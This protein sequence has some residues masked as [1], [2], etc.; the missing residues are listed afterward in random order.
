QDSLGLQGELAQEIA[1]ALRVKLTPEESARV[2]QKPTTNAQAYE[3]YL[4]ARQYEFKPDTFLQDYRTA[5]QL[6]VQAITLDPNFAL[7]HARLAAT[8]ARIYHFYEPTQAWSNSARAEATLALQLQPNLGE[9]HHAL[10]LCYYWFDRD[11]TNALRE[12]E[13]ARVLL[14]NDSSVPWDIAAIK[15]RQGHWQETVAAYLQILSLDPQNANV[16]RDLLYV[17]C[18]MRDWPNAEATAE[19]L[20]SL[21]PDS[22]NAKIQIGYVAFWSKG[23]TER[24]KREMESIP[25]GKDP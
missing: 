22:I 19:R 20:L 21:G 15:R 25:A 12:F 9:G 18:A 8:R 10:G 4:Q 6:Y 24:L 2:E 23:T 11:Y 13:I 17:Y 14:P 16:V 1:D 5:E 3:L 7:A